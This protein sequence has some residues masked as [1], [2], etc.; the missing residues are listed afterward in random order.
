M[1]K[2]Q[3]RSSRANNKQL[4]A[5]SKKPKE[6]KHPKRRRWDV[7]GEL[8]ETFPPQTILVAAEV[9]VR[10]GQLSEKLLQR[11][12]NLCLHMI[13]VWC[14]CP[15]GSDYAKSTQNNEGITAEDAAACYEEAVER[16]KPFRKRR[17][18]H[19]LDSL[20]AVKRF[21][22]E[23]LILV[24]L[25]AQHDYFGLSADMVNWWPKVKSGGFFTGHDYGKAA[26]GVT[27]AVNEF[28]SRTKLPLELG[29]DSVWII[30]KP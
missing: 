12:D 19:Q 6:K 30:R 22:D 14:E 4:P 3:P 21:A 2:K 9:G 11:F 5:K 29:D 1:K 18:I 23:S 16:T 27:Q 15:P 8:L 20:E 24:F 13:D 26:F 10:R 25:D 17:D 28:I 7:L